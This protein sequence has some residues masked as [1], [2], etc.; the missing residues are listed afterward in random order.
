MNKQIHKPSENTVPLIFGDCLRLTYPS[1]IP[2]RWRR[3]SGRDPSVLL[4]SM[5]LSGNCKIS[6]PDR[7]AINIFT[8]DNL[9][10][11]FF[12]LIWIK[13]KYIT[14]PNSEQ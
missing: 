11:N 7:I 9:N 12:K 3:K 4:E 1:K 10:W 5:I 14:N 6:N 13:K 2:D 8:G